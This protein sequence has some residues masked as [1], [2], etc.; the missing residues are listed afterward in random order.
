MARF[1]RSVLY[2]EENF[3]S[4]PLATDVFE[5]N[6]EKRTK[7]LPDFDL[8]KEHVSHKEDYDVLFSLL[9]DQYNESR[10]KSRTLKLPGKH[11]PAESFRDCANPNPNTPSPLIQ[12]FTPA[13]WGRIG[14]TLQTFC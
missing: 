1:A 8:F 14:G 12:A 7:S 9:D 10:L 13:L 11:Q 5:D 4:V 2:S 6:T 3:V